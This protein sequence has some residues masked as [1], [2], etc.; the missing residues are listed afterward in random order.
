MLTEKEL[1]EAADLLVGTCYTS[2]CVLNIILKREATYLEFDQ[3]LLYL[4]KHEI[5]ECEI[6]GWWS[7]TGLEYVCDCGEED[8]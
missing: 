7:Y 2:D 5:A 1:S 4:G 8:E 3:F 6:C